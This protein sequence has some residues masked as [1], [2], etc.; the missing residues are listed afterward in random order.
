VGSLGCTT[1]TQDAPPL[2]GPSE[3]ATSITIYASPDS[4]ARDGA[5]QSQ[6]TVQARDAR[7]R[8]IANLPIRLDA[9][10]NA[11]AADVGQ[12]STN[13]LVTGGDGR[14]STAYTAPNAPQTAGDLLSSVTILATPVGT[15]ASGSIPRSV[16]IRL[17]SASVS[18]PPTASFTFLPESPAGDQRVYFDASA[19][20]GP[21]PIT[22]YRWD[23]GD[24]SPFDYGVTPFHQFNGCSTNV[25]NATDVT[26]VVRLTVTDSAGKSS[27]P[28]A[29]V[30]TVTKCKL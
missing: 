12:F 3:L 26:F 10:G 30:V 15:D 17:T 23:F 24:G 2:A 8:P 25:A 1:K 9:R 20:T 29:K 13:Q 21:N 16:T 22:T 7:S 4:I 27:V 6:I 5:S 28:G 14:A 19:S 18:N 11:V